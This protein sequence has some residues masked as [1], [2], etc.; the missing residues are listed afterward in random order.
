[1]MGRRWSYGGGAG[2]ARREL[3]AAMATAELRELGGCACGKK[4]T[5]A[6]QMGCAAECGRALGRLRRALAWLCHAGQG[7]GDA[8]PSLATTRRT[9]SEPVGHRAGRFS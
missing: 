2:V 4:K 9:G 3:R 6:K 5:E 1:M 7:A 8:R